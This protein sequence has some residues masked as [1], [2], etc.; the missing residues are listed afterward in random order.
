MIDISNEYSGACSLR[1]PKKCPERAASK[2]QAGFHAAA[3][4]GGQIAHPTEG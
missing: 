4:D 2:R 3:A 1:L